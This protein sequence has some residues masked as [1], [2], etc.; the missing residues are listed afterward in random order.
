MQ[1]NAD[2]LALV[3]ILHAKTKNAL[4]LL[5]LFRMAPVVRGGHEER[6]K[7]RGTRGESQAGVHIAC[8]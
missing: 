7:E 8:V 2:A 6:K 1:C 4:L 5:L 3:R